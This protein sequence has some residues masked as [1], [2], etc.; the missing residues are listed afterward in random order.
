MGRYNAR[1]TFLAFSNEKPVV[2]KPSS[3]EGMNGI[4]KPPFTDFNAKAWRFLI[5][6][7]PYQFSFPIFFVKSTLLLIVLYIVFIFIQ[8]YLL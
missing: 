2:W 5:E 7:K 3:G 8:K 4:R 6:T 1:Y